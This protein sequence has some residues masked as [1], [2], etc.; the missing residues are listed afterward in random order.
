M[1]WRWGKRERIIFGTFAGVSGLVLIALLLLTQTDWGRRHVL[2]FGLDQLATRVHGK[3]SIAQIHGNLLTGARLDKVVITDTAGRPF[4]RADTVTLRYSLGSLLRRHL[5]LRDVRIVQSVVVLDQPPGEE[6]NFARIFPTGPPKPHRGPGFGSWVLIRNLA[7]K[8]ATIVVRATWQPNETLHGAARRRAVA[9]ALSTANRRWVVPV[10]GG[11]QSISEFYHVNGRFPV[12]RLADPDSANR[13]IDVQGLSMIALPFRPPAAMVHR[14]GARVVITKDSLLFDS[15][16]LVLPGT[17]ATGVGAYALNGSGARLQLNLPQV[18][19]AD[20]RV[21]RPDAPSGEGK[22]ALAYTTRDGRTHVIASKLDV[23][24]EGASVRGLADVQ[25]GKGLF[26]VGPSDVQFSRVGTRLINRYM[27]GTPLKAAG[28][29]SGDMRLKGAPSAMRVDGRIAFTELRGPTSHIVADGIVGQSGSAL[30]ARGLRL[31]FNPLYLSLLRSY[32]PNIPYHG[33]LTGVAT[34]TGS[35]RTGFAINADLVDADP[36]A[37]RSHI[38]AN[39]RIAPRDGLTA[40]NLRL[41]F[42]PLQVA[43]LKTFQ[44]DIPYGGTISGTT[45]LSGS[46]HNGFDVVADLVHNDARVGRSHVLANGRIAPRDGVTTR[47]LRL[48]LRPLQVAALKA[49]APDLPYS[50]TLTG[51]TTLT[52]STHS[53]FSIVADVTHVDPRYGTSRI[54]A[55]GRIGLRNGVT[56]DHLRLR[57]SPAQV[58]LARPY[59]KNLPYGG[60]V[61]GTT[62]LT[63]SA[64]SGFN[65]IADVTHVSNETGRSHLTAN[66]WVKFANGLSARSLRLGFDPLQMAVLEP[67]APRL[68]NEGTLAGRA[69]VT[70]SL[71]SKRLVA[72]LDLEHTGPAGPSRIIGKA[73]ANWAGRGFFDIDVRTPVLALGTVGELMPSA[74]LHGSASG[75]IVASGNMSDLRT[76]VNLAIAGGN[77]AMHTRGVFDLRSPARHYDFTS[78]LTAFNAGA[79]TTH[80]PQTRLTGTVVARGTGTTAATANAYVNANLFG[81]RAAGTPLVD[82]AIVSARLANG[83]ASIERA[84]IRLGSARGDVSGSFGLI[85]SRSGTLRYAIEIDTLSQF[86]AHVPGDSGVVAQRPLPYAR[87]LAQ[88][89]ADSARIAEASEVQRSAVGYPP[90]PALVKPDTAPFKRDTL[91]GSLRAEGTLTGNVKRFDARGTAVARHFT[92]GANHVGFGTATYSLTGFGSPDATLHLDA[93]GDTVHFNGFAFDSARARVDYTGL[94]DRGAGSADLAVYQDPNRD[95]RLRSDF[96]L[97]LDQKTALLQTLAMRFDTTTWTAT[98]P[99]RIGWGKPGVTVANLELRSNGGGYLRADGKLPTDGVADLRL[100]I[101]KLQLADVSGLLQQDTTSLQGLLSLHANVRGTTRAPVIAGDVTLLKGRYQG[102][103]LPDIRSTLSYANRDLRTHAELF[104][105]STRLAIAD[106]HLP[107]NLALA[108]V[109]GPRL[110]RAA[111]LQVDVRA[112]SLPL[113]ALPSFTRVVSDVTGRVRGNATIRGTFDHPSLNGI[114]LL[115]LGTARVNATGVLYHDIVGTIRLRGDTAYVDSVV[116]HAGGTIRATGSIDIAT[117][118]RPGFNLQVASRD[119]VLVD[120]KRG[121]IRADAQLAV[122]GPYDG[123]HVTGQTSVRSGVIY[124]PESR[125][126]RVTNLDDPTLRAS[127]DTA[128]LGFDVLPTPN[129]LMSNLQVDVDVRIAPDTWARNTQAN[130]EIYTPEDGEPLHVHMDNPHQVLTLTGVINSDRGEYTFAGRNFQ[131]STGSATFMGGPT[132]DPLLQLTARYQVQR[133]GV[134]AL[135][136]EIHV[137]GSLRQPRVTLQS[138][139]QPPLAQSDLLSYLAFGQ[140]SSSVLNMQTSSA[141]GIGNGG[142]TGIPALA[143]Q[144]IASVAMGASI[145]S[146]VA[147]I[148]K[149]G[150][151]SGLDVFRVHA[152]ELP[153]EAAFQGYFQNLVRGTEVEAGKYIRPRLFLEARG[154]LSTAPGV[155][156]QYRGPLGVT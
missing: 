32:Q 28:T 15:L 37:G 62:T 56:A 43:M 72:T 86:L 20:A 136:I 50:G 91:A 145:E 147:A 46:T 96:T 48:R 126:Q 131:L 83:L 1:A 146:A 4:L 14:L 140:P 134:E 133:R 93:F 78:T 82:T 95:Y 77:G 101:D 70:G 6:W 61:T 22:L 106:A 137:D 23:R 65:V 24:V 7:V 49:F 155:Q 122:T 55:N 98:H 97:A 39:G 19:F 79:V 31:R 104:R 29:M 63:G 142:L 135:V 154:R 109:T 41:R 123:V 107:I 35:S 149:E 47:N 64:R 25:F 130:I 10:T 117:L 128:G 100:D 51:T 87:R 121:T 116:A 54:G 88:A 144:Q 67:F 57:F 114:A 111:P 16:R 34:L 26:L 9:H 59:V 60:T 17:R 66:G 74:G 139:S 36:R 75:S 143:E 13:L 115:D 152:G 8:E 68:P 69:T 53:G 150:S 102:T 92:Y 30:T 90:P 18:R 38:L 85:A 99:A 2:A 42:A 151:R 44:P 124:A 148:Q 113:E 129:P 103:T 40:R 80:A 141:L 138:N 12:M 33:A 73:N 76:D 119:A 112:D 156:L 120:N 5:E 45:T 58:A 108:G 125:N 52:G 81:S 132:L 118:S 153:A 27:P 11:Y 105:D 127:I 94:R 71:A 3:V 84:Q 110:N 89:R 21:I